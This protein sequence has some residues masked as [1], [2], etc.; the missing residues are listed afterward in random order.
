MSEPNYCGRCGGDPCQCCKTC[1]ESPY[2]FCEC[3]DYVT[4]PATI[5]EGPRPVSTRKQV[6]P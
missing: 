6:Q 2:G 3:G 4:V 1:G 5:V